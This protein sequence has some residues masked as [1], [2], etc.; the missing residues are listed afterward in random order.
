MKC[1]PWDVLARA[2]IFNRVGKLGRKRIETS[3]EAHRLGLVAR[4]H[5]L[6]MIEEPGWIQKNIVRTP[7][8]MI[9]KLL[10]RGPILIRDLETEKCEPGQSVGSA[11]YLRRR[12][13]LIFFA[14]LRQRG[15]FGVMFCSM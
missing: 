14:I 7:M 11:E 1:T 5:G 12:L 3:K 15:D 13:C 2:Y 4:F 6:V 9:A 10:I 8:L